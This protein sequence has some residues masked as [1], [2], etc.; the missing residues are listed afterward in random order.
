MF[1]SSETETIDACIPEN[2]N[3]CNPRSYHVSKNVKLSYFPMIWSHFTKIRPYEKEG[4][5]WITY[6]K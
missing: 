5:M 2:V 6:T 3:F 4:G 1:W